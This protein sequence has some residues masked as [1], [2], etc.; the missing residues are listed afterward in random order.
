MASALGY[1]LQIRSLIGGAAPFWDGMQTPR[2][3]SSGVNP[4]HLAQHAT[5]SCCRKCAKDWHG[6]TQGRALTDGEIKYL[7]ELALR[8]LTGTACLTLP[9]KARRCRCA[10]EGA[11]NPIVMNTVDLFTEAPR[12]DVAPADPRTPRR[13]TQE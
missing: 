11:A 1:R 7:S 6:I 12:Q 13:S 10:N 2:E 5:A 3:T 9:R 4:I 8:F